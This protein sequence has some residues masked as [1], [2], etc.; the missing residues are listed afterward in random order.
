MLTYLIAEPAGKG[1]I[2]V[3]GTE[4]TSFTQANVRDGVVEYEHV[5]GEIGPNPDRDSFRLTLS[6]MS[7]QWTV[8]GNK[9]ERVD[10]QVKI[11]PVDS[12]AP[13]VTVADDFYVSEGKK[14]LIEPIH[15]IAR[16]DDTNDEDILCVITTQASEGFLENDSPLPGSEKSRAGMPISS[17]TI[18]DIVAG[19]IYFVQSVHQGSEPIEDRFSF[20]C[21]D[22]T[23]NL[24]DQM[25]FNIAIIPG[26]RP[27]ICLIR[28]CAPFF[29]NWPTGL[30][31][32]LYF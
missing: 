30:I 18:G 31:A 10:I 4:A 1:V 27:P 32:W 21:Q 11:L 2:L 6:D 13:V 29:T 22:G 5:A 28:F 17:F 8:G 12:E 14:A 3:E 19:N 23:P 9:V 25:F 15:L 26:M 16:D 20:V 7:D 24:S